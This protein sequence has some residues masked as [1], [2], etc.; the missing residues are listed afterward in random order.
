MANGLTL[1]FA[2]LERVLSTHG[3]VV[4][5][6]DVFGVMSGREQMGSCQHHLVSGGTTRWT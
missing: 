5:L 1:S 4:G 2:K 6:R 3:C